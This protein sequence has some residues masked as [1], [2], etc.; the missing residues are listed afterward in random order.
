MPSVK[1][2]ALVSFTSHAPAALDLPA[3]SDADAPVHASARASR[4]GSSTLD[5]SKVCAVVGP[6]RRAPRQRLF[7]VNKGRV[8]RIDATAGNCRTCGTRFTGSAHRRRGGGIIA[9]S[10]T[11]MMILK[12]ENRL[13]RLAGGS[14][15]DHGALASSGSA[16]GNNL[17]FFEPR[18][19]SATIY[20]V[21]LD[22]GRPRPKPS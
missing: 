4:A 14:C 13:S 12:N 18:G 20:F 22:A 16:V 5:R 3:Q 8:G 6:S 19:S 2:S 15:V 9:R 21:T 7:G 1:G 17:Q 10:A 11:S